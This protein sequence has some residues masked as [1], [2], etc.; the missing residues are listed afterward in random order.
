MYRLWRKISN[1][2]QKCIRTLI[3]KLDNSPIG[4]QSITRTSMMK[5]F[6]QKRNIQYMY[7]YPE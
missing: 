3:T 7:M 5:Y 2:D 4:K 1:S 6:Y